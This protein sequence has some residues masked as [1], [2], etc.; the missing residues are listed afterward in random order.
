MLRDICEQDY[1]VFLKTLEESIMAFNQM[2]NQGN[3]LEYFETFIRYI[4][5]ARNDLEFQ[6]VYELAK[7]ISLERSEVFMTIAERLITEGMEKGIEKGMEKGK[8]EVAE[9][10]L[11]LGMGVDMIMKATGLSEE[12]IRKI[13]N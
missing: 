7:E 8:L 11:R 12:E 5:S 3:G 9:N 1:T 2:E 13:M 10:L 4:M 6:T